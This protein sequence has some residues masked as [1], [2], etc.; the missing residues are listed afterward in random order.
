MI[1]RDGELSVKRQAQLL[2]LSRSSVYYVARALPERDLKLM[3]ILDEL[4]LKWPF[5]G[6]R[7]LT[8]E[9][10]NQGHEVGRR[11]VTTLMRRMGMETIYR[12]P[13]TSIPAP[14]SAVYPYLLTGLKIERANHVWAADL[15]YLPMAHGFQYLV[16]I[17][18]VG[19]RKT[20]AWRV[21]NTM[22]P[23]FCVEALQ[24]ALG[25]YGKPEIF[26]TDQGSQPRL[27]RSSQRSL[28]S[29]LTSKIFKAVQSDA[30][31][32]EGGARCGARSW[33]ISSSQDRVE[34]FG[35]RSPAESLSRSAVEGDS[36]CVE[37]LLRVSADVRTFRKVLP[38]QPVSVLV[39]ST[40]PRTLR[41]AEI[42]SQSG[43]DP[44]LSVLGQLRPLVPGQR[45][46][47]VRRQH[48][49]LFGDGVTDGSGAATSQGRSVL[50]PGSG[51]MPRHP[52]QMQQ[53]RESRGALD[54]RSDCRAVQADDHVA[55]PVT[56][57]SAVC[58]FGGALTDHH[59]GRDKRLAPLPRSGTW[60]PQRPTR[61]KTGR[62][63]SSQC[64]STL[65]IKCLVDGF[66]G[67]PHAHI[68][69]E[70]DQQ[71]SA[72]LLRAPAL[73]PPSIGTAA[74]APPLP[75]HLRS[76]NRRAAGVG[77]SASESILHIA[78]QPC[79]LGKLGVFGSRGGPFSLP[80]RDCGPISQYTAAGLRVAT[81][82]ARNCRWRSLHPPG[83][84]AN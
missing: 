14:L 47:Q 38:Q 63:L 80:L 51:Y 65:H 48:L 49:D 18:D 10:Q 57:H 70:V 33:L 28:R 3:R 35:W 22:T 21:S 64:A 44:K 17:I 12:K 54:Q 79:V 50:N 9:L 41:I 43:F 24:E 71:S 76:L 37:L 52:W 42:D 31:A 23:D 83:N 60:Y 53:H 62:Q 82:L 4:H 69:R 78:S 72:D 2:D 68:M 15:T 61:T 6:A 36:H 20:L 25:K 45:S 74:M 19:S 59:L 8:R 55:L 75:C 7:K 84:L 5:Y 30:N 39:G 16:A 58:S 77:N 29:Y 67:D 1:E 11:H 26:N 34:C 66:V 40:L 13:R 32:S 46:S 56:W 81:Q 27:N 73:A